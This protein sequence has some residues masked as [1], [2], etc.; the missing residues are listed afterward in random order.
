MRAKGQ[1]LRT[2]FAVNYVY[3]RA[4]VE[5]LERARA[6]RAAALAAGASTFES[7]EPTAAGGLKPN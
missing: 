3:Q 1:P 7:A 2:E 6:E 5:M 4:A